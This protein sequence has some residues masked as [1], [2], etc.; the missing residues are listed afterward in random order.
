MYLESSRTDKTKMKEQ[1]N[2]LY[3]HQLSGGDQDFEKR[4]LEVVKKELPQ[5]IKYFQKMIAE[6]NFKE[7]SVI[8][9]KIKHKISILGLTDSYYFAEKYEEELR[10]GVNSGQKSFQEI[11][12]AMMNFIDQV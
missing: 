3:I 7:A 6:E 8:V 11:L 4:M 12:E 2:M 10:L 5:D 1:P 9:H